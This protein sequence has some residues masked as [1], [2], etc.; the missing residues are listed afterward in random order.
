M[1]RRN[2]AISWNFWKHAERIAADVQGEEGRMSGLPTLE[3]KAKAARQEVRDPQVPARSAL[4][5]R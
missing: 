5:M 4:A 3:Q 1:C 2:F